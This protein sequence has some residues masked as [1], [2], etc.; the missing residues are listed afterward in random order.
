VK[1]LEP[2]ASGA[3]TRHSDHLSYTHHPCLVRLE[4]FELSTHG[5]E[6]R[7][8]IQLS[9]RRL[10]SRRTAFY[11]LIKEVSYILIILICQDLNEYN[12]A[13]IVNERIRQS[14]QNGTLF[15]RGPPRPGL[16]YRNGDPCQGGTSDRVLLCHSD[17]RWRYCRSILR[18]D[19]L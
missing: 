8:S 3:T 18:R 13:P 10:S 19:N 9:Y 6:V 17:E 2:S 1:G 12:F 11:L 15:Y 5:L 4:G 7:C 16:S 14:R